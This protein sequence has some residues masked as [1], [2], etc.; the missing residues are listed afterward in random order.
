M[1]RPVPEPHCDT[2]AAYEEAVMAH[3][4]DADATPCPDFEMSDRF[5]AWLV[6]E[7][8]AEVM[9]QVAA[10]GLDRMAIVKAPDEEE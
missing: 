8:R 10:A 2:C 7:M 5:R 1:A 3:G 9:G 6:Q 4:G